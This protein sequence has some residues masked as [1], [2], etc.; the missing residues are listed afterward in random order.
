MT[1]SFVHLHLHTQ[2]SLLDG[3][4]QIEPLIRQ[5]KTFGQPAVAM[6]DHGNMFGA[7]EFYRKAKEIGVKPIIGCEAYMAL[8]SRHAKK[9]SGLAHNDYYHLILLARNLTGYQNLIKLVSKAYLEGFYYKPRMD[10]E[11]LKEHHEGLIALSGCLS[12]E[13]PYLIGQKDMAGALAV[14]GE[15]QEL[16]GKEHFYL[17]VQANGLDHQRIANA[18]LIEIHKKLGIPLAGT[19][20]CHYLKKEDARPHELMLCLQTGKTLSDPAR[21]KFDTDQLYVKST[22]EIAPAFAEFPGAVANTCRIADCCDLELALNKTHLPQYKAPEGYTRESYV[23]YLAI[24]G[25]KSRLTERPSTIPLAV[26]EQRLREEL[27]VICSMGFAGYFLIVWDIIRFARNRNIPVGPGRGSAAGSL[28]AYALRITDL[29]PLVYTLL[30]ER[31]LNPERVSLPDIDMDFC[32]DRRGEVL[33]YVV[34]KYG[35]D[36]VAQIIT[37]GTLGAKAAIRDV[38]RVMEMP[39]ADADKVAKLVPNQLNITLE[40]AL[41][42]E[43]RLRELVETDPKVRELM[44]IARSL[45]GL[46]RHASTHAAGVVISEEPLT[47]H[48]P[49]YK[50]A[51][52]EIVTQYSMGDVEKIGLVKFDFLGLKTLTMIRRAETLIHESHPGQPPLSVE[53]LPFDDAKTFALLSSGK[54]TGIFQL[55]SSGMRD[56][57]SGFKPDRFEDIIAIIALYRPGPM[58][59]IPDFIKRKQGKVPIVYELPELEPI[60][61]DTYGVIV[62]QEQVMAIANTVAGFS[63]GQADILR[64]A[65][66]KKKPEEME[67]LRVK[68]LEGARQNKI[69]EKKAEKLY[70]L[71]QKFAGYGFNKSHAAAYAVVCYHT[72]YLKAHYPTEFMAAL[73]T[74][75]MGNQD[76]IVG[77]FTECRDLGIK[78][79]GPDVNE[80]QKNFAVVDGAIRFGLAAIKNVGEGAVDSVLAIRADSGRFTSFFDFCRRVDLHKVNKR[81][82]EG[83]IKAGAF[84]SLGAK[85][86]Q[87]MAMLDHGIEDGAAAQQERERGQTSIFGEELNGDGSAHGHIEPALPNVPEWDQAQRLKYERELTGFYITAHPLARYEATIHALATATTVGIAELSDGKEVRLCGIIATVKSMLTKK[88]DRM[89]YMTLEDLQGTV[90][91]IVFPDLFKTVG[92]LIAPERLIRV[93]GTI[94]RGDKGTKIRGTKI[95]PLADV[96]T[97]SIKRIHIRLATKPEVK[98]QLPRLLDVFKRHPGATA[99]S[100]TFRTES[101]LEAE[102]AP[103]PHLTVSATESFLADVEEVLGKGALSL[104]S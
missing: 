22:D 46:A 88:G 20:D 61:K 5:I 101:A 67:K 76:K 42:T 98:D 86:S 51:N 83:L 9:D 35:S 3:A 15:F 31:F 66:G 2:F 24:E 82:L 48:V 70:E 43:P 27:M 7:I 17:E 11:I 60:L 32:M 63:L 56:L 30:F 16:F 29:D 57:L 78:V 73:M 90:E 77:Y 92:E 12:G 38:G 21:M 10:K 58:D 81:M 4:N 74:T 93:T 36:H 50:G 79:L 75:D 37:F 84:D 26:Y 85:R 69:A 52:D 96:Q 102:T 44:T 40:Q 1:A 45:E 33:N 23:E 104:V 34:E 62:Y 72:G 94:D 6:T 97:Q 99:V 89:A 100:L 19:N 59:L 25:L 53:L 41:E 103:L 54:T 49:L 8:G 95:E 39:Y 55:E 68:F 13:I 18:G 65:M 80:S 87:L 14:A 28:V 64:R 47:D 91:V 71:I